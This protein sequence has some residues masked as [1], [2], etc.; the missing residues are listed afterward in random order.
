[1][2]AAPPSGG[3]NSGTTFSDF[4]DHYFGNEHSRGVGRELVYVVQTGKGQATLE[5]KEFIRKYRWKNNP[6]AVQLTG[7]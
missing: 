6:G 5:F 4:G 3:G 1:V 7:K 2:D